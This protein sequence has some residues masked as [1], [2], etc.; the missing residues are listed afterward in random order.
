[1]S[2][3]QKRKVVTKLTGIAV[4]LNELM[5]ETYL[6]YL[7][8]KSFIYIIVQLFLRD[9]IQQELRDVQT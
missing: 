9:L 6:E 1:M 2:S 7:L 8:L 5:L 4:R 3:F